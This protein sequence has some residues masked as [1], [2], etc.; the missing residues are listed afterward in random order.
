MQSS[1]TGGMGCSAVVF[2][3]LLRV[4][5]SEMEVDPVVCRRHEGLQKERQGNRLCLR[6]R[7]GGFVLPS[8]SGM[9]LGPGCE[10]AQSLWGRIRAAQRGGTMAGT[11]WGDLHPLAP[12]E[13]EQGWSKKQESFGEHQE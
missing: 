12:R 4:S 6:G 11:P 2:N 7:G 8:C 9:C 3:L 1:I 13:K 5:I 10:P